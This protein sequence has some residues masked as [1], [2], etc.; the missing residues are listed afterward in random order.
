MENEQDEVIVDNEEET[1]EEQEAVDGAE[2]KLKQ[3]LSG[4][5]RKSL[6]TL[7]VVPLD[8]ARN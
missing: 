4:L 2:V 7:K 6:N 5:H 3:N 1:N 8:F